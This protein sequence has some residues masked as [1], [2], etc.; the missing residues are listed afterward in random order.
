M[1]DAGRHRRLRQVPV[2]GAGDGQ[3]RG[4]E[5]GHGRDDKRRDA[6]RRRGTGCGSDVGYPS[7]RPEL[8]LSSD[9]RCGRRSRGRD[10]PV[11]RRA[12]RYFGRPSCPR[13]VDRDAR[14][15]GTATSASLPHDDVPAG[16]DVP[17]DP[18]ARPARS[19][20]ARS[21]PSTASRS[22]SGAGEFFSLLGPSGCGKT[23]TLRM[24]GGF[25]LPTG[26]THPAARPRRHQ[27]PAGQA[28]GQHGLPELRAVPAPRR[29]RQRRVRAQAHGRRQGRDRA[30]G[31]RGARARPPRRLRA[32]PPE[33]AVGRPAA[34][35]RAR[36]RAG[37]PARTCCS[38]TSRSARSTSS[39]AASSRSSSSASRP[40][41]G[42]PSCT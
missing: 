41:S 4:R 35:R 13:C 27:R 8:P 18:A 42:S 39:C 31:R 11:G 23:T 17:R 38:S 2:V 22:R 10:G 26:G 19:D 9:H 6:R 21:G 29:R 30:P 33:P 28:P 12:D 1:P 25:E 5:P 40:R 14:Q 20:S 24:I 37:Q 16:P 7:G 34:A 32:A 3:D 36:P 15:H